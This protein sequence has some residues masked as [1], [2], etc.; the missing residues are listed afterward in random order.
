MD[1]LSSELK[2]RQET[3]N[4]TAWFNL[5]K[6]DKLLLYQQLE[7]DPDSM[8]IREI[9]EK[10]R[11]KIALDRY[12][13]QFISNLAVPTYQKFSLYNFHDTLTSV[14]KHLFSTM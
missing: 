14:V 2:T 9:K 8:L 5:T 10:S 11:I 13:D 3:S 12:M 1:L 6:D 7:K 4:D